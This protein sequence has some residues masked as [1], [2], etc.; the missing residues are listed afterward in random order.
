MIGYRL[1][2]NG[3]NRIVVLHGWLGDSSVFD[4]MLPALDGDRFSFAF[5]DYRGYGRSRQI[6][7]D[8]SLAEIAHDAIA[9]ADALGW[10]RF[11]LL[12]HSM[13]GA[14][15]LRVTIDVPE[16]VSRIVAATPVPAGGVAFGAEE[17]KLFES[18]QD[19]EEARQAI[20]DFTTGSRHSG[21]WS[22]W[23]CRRSLETSDP[24]ALGA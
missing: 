19:N 3:A 12:G 21:A 13:G 8:H 24:A 14:V 20:I 2:G 22:R 9:L 4:P 10:D 16:R 15:A 7:G 6:A 1:V 11:G 18:A 17:R 23:M 5:L